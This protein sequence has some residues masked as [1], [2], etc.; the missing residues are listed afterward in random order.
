M[1]K[2]NIREPSR[3][4]EGIARKMNVWEGK[5]HDEIRFATILN[6]FPRLGGVKEGITEITLLQHYLVLGK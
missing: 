5:R 4:L 3:V 1:L 2:K 6:C